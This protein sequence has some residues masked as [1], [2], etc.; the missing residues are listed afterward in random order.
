M[1]LTSD[2]RELCKNFYMIPN[3]IMRLGLSAGEIAVYNYLMYCE[4]RRTY[5]CYPSYRKMGKAL[6][7]TRK[8]VMKYVKSLEEKCL[9]TTEHTTATL[10]SGKKQNG[11]LL[12]TIRPI[13]DAVDYFNACQFE[14]AE[15]E[16]ARINAIR[17]LEEYDRKHGIIDGNRSSLSEAG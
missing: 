16:T 6:N 1:I 8:T 15:R 3:E 13:K 4:D 7:L 17:K 5:Q 10:K 2:K 12:Y 9:I 14:K 11:N